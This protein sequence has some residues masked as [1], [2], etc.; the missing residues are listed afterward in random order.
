MFLEEGGYHLAIDNT[1]YVSGEFDWEETFVVL[2]IFT[3]FVS[4]INPEID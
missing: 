3:L 4:Y 1:C 2:E